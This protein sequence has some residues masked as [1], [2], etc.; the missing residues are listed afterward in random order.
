M[1][2]PDATHNKYP[3][4]VTTD[5]VKP[6]SS[7]VDDEYKQ[8]ED[9]ARTT[10]TS[11]P[12]KRDGRSKTTVR[13]LRIR[14]DRAKYL[15]DLNPSSAFYDPKSRSLR[16]DFQDA[17]TSFESTGK[18]VFEGDS[19][20]FFAMHNYAWDACHERPSEVPNLFAEPSATEVLYEEMVRRKAAV[21]TDSKKKLA[22]EYGG[23]Q[24][25]KAPPSALLL[26]QTEVYTEYT[27]EGDLLED[28][29]SIP[30]S[31]YP[32][33]VLINDHSSVW[34]SYY[35]KKS[36]KWG[37]AC[38]RQLDKMS[39]CTGMISVPTTGISASSASSASSSSSSSSSANTSSTVTAKPLPS[40]E[41]GED[42]GT[43]TNNEPN[44]KS[45]VKNHDTKK[46]KRGNSSS[47]S[48]S[49]SDSES[50]SESPDQGKK[51]TK[52][53]KHKHKKRSGKKKHKH[54]S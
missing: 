15:D 9:E 12:D 37:Y 35:D 16:G 47:G 30:K 4:E 1:T 14:E 3:H 42:I 45:K 25:M 50:D 36:G 17:E 51:K 33:D 19:S 39:V 44:K 53:K 49:E 22:Q 13:N 32:E 23:E 5:A 8:N 52:H 7:L 41:S 48:E 40:N 27:R 43:N 29:T 6:P 10:V 20:K 38:C 54:P 18:Q 11:D 24:Y 28:P 21:E 2:E 46:R 31:K 34:G 26:G